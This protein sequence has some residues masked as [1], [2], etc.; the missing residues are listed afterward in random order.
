VGRAFYAA[1]DESVDAIAHGVNDFSQLVERRP[2]A[3]TNAI[4]C[5]RR[6]AS[7]AL[8]GAVDRCVPPTVAPMKVRGA[9]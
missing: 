5:D 4:R 9:N 7:L 8:G 6:A 2:R 3:I 1:V